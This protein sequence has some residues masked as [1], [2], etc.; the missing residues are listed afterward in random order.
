M[1]VYFFI[2][3]FFILILITSHYRE[4]M[5]QLAVVQSQPPQ[6]QVVPH[7]GSPYDRERRSSYGSESDNSEV[8]WLREQKER[9]EAKQEVLESHN[10]QLE[11]QLQRLRL[12]ITQV[13]YYCLQCT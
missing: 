7:P 2:Y 1:L 11:L 6:M 8:D 10:K 12:L 13:P 5:D 3:L 9:L 4:L